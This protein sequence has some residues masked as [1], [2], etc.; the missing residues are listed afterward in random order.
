MYYEIDFENSEDYWNALISFE[1]TYC[2][3]ETI[4]VEE[5][6]RYGVDLALD[7]LALAE[8]K[9]GE[10]MTWATRDNGTV[11]MTMD[12]HEG[13]ARNRETFDYYAETGRLKTTLIIAKRVNPA[14]VALFDVI[15]CEFQH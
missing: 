12:P 5:V 9:D 10:V 15:A 14:G 11:Y 8:L 2:D 4:T 7:V 13:T 1:A 3:A 6:E